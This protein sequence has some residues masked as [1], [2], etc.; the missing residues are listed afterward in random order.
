MKTERKSREDSELEHER[1]KRQFE[2]SELKLRFYE[3]EKDHIKEMVK[4]EFEQK[5]LDFDKVKCD[6]EELKNKL[7]SLSSDAENEKKEYEKNVEDLK[8]SIKKLDTVLEEHKK[9][10]QQLRFD[11][12]KRAQ[13]LMEAVKLFVSSEH[14]SINQQI[15]QIDNN[16]E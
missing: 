6:N 11:E 15:T 2:E 10:I 9:I 12:K 4:V 3:E 1:A 13:G 16:A 7:T 5:L 8:A 14:E